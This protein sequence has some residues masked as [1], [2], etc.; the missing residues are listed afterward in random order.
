MP[1]PRLL[2]SMHLEQ[3]PS[4]KKVRLRAAPKSVSSTTGRDVQ[5]ILERR[6]SREK[7]H[8]GS[9]AIVLSLPLPG[10]GT[11]GKAFIS[12]SLSFFIHKMELVIILTTCK[13]VAR[14]H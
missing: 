3:F 4:A 7:N 13:A 12:L 9:V 11:L 2:P 5:A 1:R 10:S 8:V 14:S 6:E